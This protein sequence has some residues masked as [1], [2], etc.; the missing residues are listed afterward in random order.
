M[1]PEKEIIKKNDIHAHDEWPQLCAPCAAAVWQLCSWCTSAK[2]NGTQSETKITESAGKHSFV[3]A[4]LDAWLVSSFVRAMLRLAPH[5]GLIWLCRPNQGQTAPTAKL[6]G[7]LGHKHLEQV[8]GR[9]TSGQICWEKSVQ[10]TTVIYLRTT[11]KRSH[12][13]PHLHK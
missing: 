11:S 7:R 12:T 8:D 3:H 4:S 9:R 1:N 10:L 2:I 13:V 5:P 6:L